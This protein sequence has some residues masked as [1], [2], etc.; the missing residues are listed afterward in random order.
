MPSLR[1]FLVTAD[2]MSALGFPVSE[3]CARAMG[4]LQVPSL[5]PRRGAKVLG[6]SMHFPNATIV[7]FIAL[8][9]F[10]RD[11]EAPGNKMNWSAV[12]RP[13]AA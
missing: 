8:T 9:C 7:L 12:K 10:G 6:N 13:R 1:R 5:D 3:D 4:V 11:F 2:K